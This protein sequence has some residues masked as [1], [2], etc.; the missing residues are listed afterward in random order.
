MLR[1]LTH[2]E[3]WLLR[4]EAAPEGSSNTDAEAESTDP[5][6][7]PIIRCAS[8]GHHVTRA[9][10]KTAI[11][12]QH[13]HVCVNPSGIP[14]HIG[15]FSAAPGCTDHGPEESY[16]SWFE[17][18]RWQIALCTACRRHLGWAFRST[19]GGFHGL[20]LARL[21]EDPQAEA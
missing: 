18:Y 9:G 17:G 20:I 13:E 11:R 16:W 21:R 8:C 5:E 6:R 3:P 15:C 4:G 2:I 7:G 19:D 14:F 1:G 12:G 10:A